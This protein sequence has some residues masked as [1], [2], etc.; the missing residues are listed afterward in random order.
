MAEIYGISGNRPPESFRLTDPNF[1]D[2]RC[3][4]VTPSDRNTFPQS[5]IMAESPKVPSP[6]ATSHTPPAVT[7]ERNDEGNSA[8][9]GLPTEPRCSDEET[10]SSTDNTARKPRTLCG[11]C[12]DVVAKYKCPRCPLA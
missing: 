11:V 1:L 10:A 12:N 7:T 6:T 4:N 9:E 5:R 3:F 8:T 2:W